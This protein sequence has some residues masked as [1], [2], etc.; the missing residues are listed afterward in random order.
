MSG[1]EHGS[2]Q[3]LVR[4]PLEPHQQNQLIVG[5]CFGHLFEVIVHERPTPHEGNE[6]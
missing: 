4:G 3:R 2:G 6:T 1:L 5:L